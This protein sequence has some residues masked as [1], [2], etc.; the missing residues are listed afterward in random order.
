MSTLNDKIF[1]DYL[2]QRPTNVHSPKIYDLKTILIYL[3]YQFQ[4]SNS[5]S[6]E[7]KTAPFDARFPNQNQ[8]K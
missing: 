7:I 1:F 3:L 8:T 4:M 5:D 2:S 6:I